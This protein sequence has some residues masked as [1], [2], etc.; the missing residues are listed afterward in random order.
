MPSELALLSDVEPSTER[1]TTIA[2]TVHPDGA[3]VEFRGGDIRQFVDAAGNPLLCLFRT[4]P[5]L[6]A[7]EAAA[8][9]AEPPSAFALWTDL[10]V[11]FGDDGRGRRLAEAIAREL[12]GVV[13][14][15]V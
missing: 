2:A 5:V 8:A 12:G 9:L 10:T 13:S 11:P 3:Y 1:I 6:V 14:E 4:R 15:R 7:R